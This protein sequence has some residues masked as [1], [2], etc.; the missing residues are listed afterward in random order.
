MKKLI[1]LSLMLGAMVVVVPSVEAKAGPS[2]IEPAQQIIIQPTRNRRGR[3]NRRTR[4]VTSTRITW[5]GPYRYRETIRTTY[6]ANGRTRTVV[7][8]RVRL[9]GRRQWR[10]Y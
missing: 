2:A 5:V 8:N 9:S 1:S 4:T 6:F 10:N 3:W 7:V